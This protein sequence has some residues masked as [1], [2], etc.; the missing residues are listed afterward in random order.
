[1]RFNIHRISLTVICLLL[2]SAVNATTLSEIYNLAVVNDPQ[3]GA[4]QASYMARKEVVT[5]ARA[6]L[7]PSVGIGGSRSENKRAVL[8]GGYGPQFESH[9]W[10][11]SINQPV[12]RLDSWFQ[13]QRAKNVRAQAKADFAAAQQDLIVRV[14]ESYFTILEAEDGLTASEAAK[15]ATERQLEQVQQRFDVGLVAITDVLEAT[16]E[17]DSQAVTVIEAEGAQQVSFESLLRLTGER[18]EEI[19]GLSAEFPVEYPEPRDEDVWVETALQQNLNLLA[20][21]EGIKAAQKQVQVARTGHYPT[22]DASVTYSHSVTGGGDFFGSKVNNQ[23]AQLQL[24]IPIY[25]G[26]FTHSRVK[27][28]IFNLEAAQKN[29]ELTQKT[30]VEQTRSMYTAINTDVGRV[31]ARL[32]G[33]ESSQSALDATQTGYE[34]GTRNIV[35]VLLAQQ[36]LYQAQFQYASAKYKYILNTFRIKQLAG[37]LS[38]EDIVELTGFLDTSTPVHKLSRKK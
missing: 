31:Q 20:A 29:L 28:A 9:G 6:G 22:V 2:A 35:D 7:L 5:Q 16:A 38:P 27:E 10:G 15:D 36:R 4:A 11:A 8:P 3:L 18:M 13:F 19:A 24:N 21:K 33:I 1:M 25:S 37:T 12:F 32:K 23:S 17:F 14:A 34:V 30:V 26:G